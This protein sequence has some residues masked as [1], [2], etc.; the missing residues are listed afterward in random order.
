MILQT[1]RNSLSINDF[2]GKY[3]RN[4]IPVLALAAAVLPAVCLSQMQMPAC[5]TMPAN[6]HAD[7][8]SA[9]PPPQHLAGIGNLHFEIGSKNPE[10]R[11]W[12]D[13]GMNL[14]FDFWDYEAERAFEQA[15]RTD[16]NCAICHWALY[17]SL[18]FRG[19]ESRGYA[20]EELAHAISLRSRAN[21]REKLYIEAAQEE[22]KTTLTPEAG[23]EQVK[24][25]LRKIVKKYPSDI[26]A[27]LL[28]AEALQDGY[29][30][31]KPRKGT[32][33]AI[34]LLQGILKT[35]PNDSAANHLWIHAVEAS[36][37][38][39]Q[40]I[41]SAKLLASLAP[42]SGHMTHMPG[43]IF[44]RTG[45]YARAQQSFDLSESVDEAYMRAQSVSV[46]DDW[47]YVHNL[48][49]SIANLM[50]EGHLDQAAVVSAKLTAARGHRSATL[51]PQSPR[52]SIARLNPQLPVALRVGDWPRIGQLLSGVAPSDS[53]P[54]LQFLA[55]VLSGFAQ[56]MQKVNDND[57][58]SAR[59]LSTT[60]D[61]ELWR[62]SQRINDEEALKK[63]QPQA[64]TQPENFDI[65]PD[66]QLKPL[67]KN[68]SIFSLEL[69]AAILVRSHQL[70][71][72]EKLFTQA[73]R[74][75]QELGYHEPPNFIQPVAEQEASLLLSAD[76][77]SEAR[78]AWQHALDD[79]PNS[80]FSLY[81]LASTSEKTGNAEQTTAAYREFLAAWNTADPDLPQV[82]H[83]QQ[84]MTAHQPPQS[85][86]IR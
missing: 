86:A 55:R 10:T 16:P 31:G 80:G 25:I 84:W 27:R 67:L 6:A 63:K 71:E 4:L 2:N 62:Q 34:S 78:N 14:L 23:D 60:L 68:V 41:E 18:S 70:T 39:E 8:P 40:A 72:A 38:P 37:H 54:N 17:E 5:H 76:Y 19:P 73:R 51:Y 66:P 20:H 32:Q 45:D 79:R 11:L 24:T 69:R 1:A 33:E 3:M 82:R 59:N 58:D 50:E 22:E 15:V 44:Y 56:G 12:F 43:H 49:Y 75:E 46:D 7:L 85:A 9:L 83:A 61:A 42:S 53:M 74:E 35:N 47:N 29:D 57:L 77:D 28:L 30:N 64:S 52:D 48:M 26:T 36:P 81:G 21:N 65:S 13:Q